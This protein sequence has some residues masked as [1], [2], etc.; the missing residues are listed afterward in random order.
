LS[1]DVG[2]V[3]DPAENLLADGLAVDVGVVFELLDNVS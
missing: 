3:G 1:L 2:L